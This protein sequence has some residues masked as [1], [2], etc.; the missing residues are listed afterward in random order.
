[1]TLPPEFLQEVLLSAEKEYPR[2]CCGF[3]LSSK[4]SGSSFRHV[5]I[6]NAQDELHRQDPVRFSRTARSAYTMDAGDLLRVH[7]ELKERDETVYAIYHSHP[8]QGAFFSVEDRRLALG[9]QDE[10]VYANV[11]YLVVSVIRGKAED[12]KFFH[13]DRESKEFTE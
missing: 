7:K 5:R 11:F 8:D 9:D 6:H 13:W 1:M 12:W 4:T 3:I 10:P 2:E